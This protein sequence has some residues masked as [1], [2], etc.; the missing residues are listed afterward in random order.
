MSGPR[1]T[2]VI[3][4]FNEEGIVGD[5]I[6]SVQAQTRPDWVATVVDD[7]SRDGTAEVVREIAAG[8]QRVRLLSKENEGLSAARNSAIEIADT[9]L[10]SFL[11][12]DDRW[13]P[14]YLERMAAALD[15]A[16]DAGMAYTD[17]WALDTDRG[18]FRRAT[19]MSSCRP[20]DVL[21][22]EPDQIMRLLV[23]QNF[24][25]VSVTMRRVAL[26][27]AGRFRAD[28]TSAE[29]IE[30]WFRLLAKGWTLVGPVGVL[31]I[32]GER[33]E[34]MSRQDLKNF[35][36]L[37]RV[38]GLVCENPE[39]PEDVKELARDEVRTLERWRLALSGE[40]RLLSAG[41]AARL[42][43]GKVKRFLLAR[44]EWRREPPPE[45]REAFGDLQDA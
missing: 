36:N 26:E 34:A 28:M 12:A 23:R 4:A 30:L 40:S 13:L 42:H 39:V 8:D 15:A 33:P 7:G 6:R 3:P 31:G 5:A 35:V 41:L 16:P 24:I 25:W 43:L 45:V 44:R 27:Q 22:P 37:Q 19:A 29:D 14:T 10:I 11:D 9:E 21:P 17:A 20:P 18:R 1:F 32:K 38:M 2:V